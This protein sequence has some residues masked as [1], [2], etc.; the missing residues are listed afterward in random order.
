M[1]ELYKLDPMAGI[2]DEPAARD[3]AAAAWD[4]HSW[5][6]CPLHAAYGWNGLG[7]APADRRRDVAAFVAVFDATLLPQPQ[8]PSFNS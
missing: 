6:D 1:W 2:C 5:Q 3:R 4:K 8:A 7:D